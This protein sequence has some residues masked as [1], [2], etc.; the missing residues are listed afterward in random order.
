MLLY[1]A[2]KLEPDTVVL[3]NLGRL[4]AL[5]DVICEAFPPKFEVL[6]GFRDDTLNNAC[7]EAGLPASVKSLHL[8]GC[9]ADIR[10]GAEVYTDSVWDWIEEN[11]EKIGAHE[12]IFYPNKDFIHVAV[13]DHDQ[14][15]P[16][17]ILMR[18]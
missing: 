1:L 5:L 15:G 8:T 3:A 7:I 9:A 16:R 12:A 10:P 18:T 11:A 2:D 4:T 13:A 6:S 17:R 14:P